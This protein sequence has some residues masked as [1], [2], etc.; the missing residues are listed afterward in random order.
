MKTFKEKLHKDIFSGFSYTE[1][2]SSIK[3]KYQKID[4]YKHPT[5][6][7]VLVLD[8]I[9]QLAT[10]DEF[11]F[12]ESI[13]YWPF[14]VK[15]DIKNILIIGGG[16]LGIA[17]R[18]LKIKKDIS[19][20]LVEIDKNVTDVSLEY[21]YPKER[22]VLSDSRLQLVYKDAVDFIASD[23][24]HY[25]LIIVD[26][27]DDCGVGSVLYK[28]NF[29]FNLK[30]RLTDNGIL[31]RLS[32]SFFLQKK[33]F[34]TINKQS[35]KIFGKNSVGSLFLPLNMYQGGIYTVNVCFKNNDFI[36]TP[37]NNFNAP[38]IWYNRDRHLGV[39]TLL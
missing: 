15:K 20:T 26:S 37:T 10:Q 12:H 33:E 23:S 1:K 29:I 5:L 34:E 30:T 13:A 39:S 38:G 3:S 31:M 24:N 32:G 28:N 35:E 4:V 8:N 25:D 17:I 18:L 16:D 7:K 6:G 11:I 14:F 9:V 2:L 21:I 27:T 36:Y 19:V 22:K